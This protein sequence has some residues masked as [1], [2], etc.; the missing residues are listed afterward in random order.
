VTVVASAEVGGSADF[1]PGGHVRA[2]VTTNITGGTVNVYLN[3]L[4]GE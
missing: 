4:H 1:P 3:A 2:R